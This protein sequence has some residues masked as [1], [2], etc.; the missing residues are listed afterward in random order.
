MSRISK[1]IDKPLD[2]YVTIHKDSTMTNA[3]TTYQCPLCKLPFSKRE[4]EG[5]IYQVHSARAE[6]AF[7]ML[8]GLTYPVRCTCGKE[9]R[10]NSLHK[11]F[12]R[13]CGNCSTGAV[14]SPKYQNADDAH[15]HIEQLQAMLEQARE[16]EK[17]LKQEAEISRKPLKELPFP[18]YKYNNFMKKLSMEIRFNAVQ[19]DKAKLLELA[20]YI[21]SKVNE[22]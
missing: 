13:T 19:M 7:A 17:R 6:E 4:F 18:S 20:N 10:Y 5:H 3:R 15:K 9:L 21:D 12:P 14:E 16:A 11:G 8:Y 22:Q 2:Q 1:F